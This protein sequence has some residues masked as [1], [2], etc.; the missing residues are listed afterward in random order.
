MTV[1]MRNI[2]NGEEPYAAPRDVTMTTRDVTMTTRDVTS[3]P[4][5]KDVPPQKDSHLYSKRDV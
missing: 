4:P 3:Q 2:H 5:Q 1:H